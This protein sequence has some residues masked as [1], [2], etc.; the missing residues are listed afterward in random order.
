MERETTPSWKIPLEKNPFFNTSHRGISHCTFEGTTFQREASLSVFSPFNPSLTSPVTSLSM[1]IAWWRDPPSSWNIDTIA[2]LT[3][4]EVVDH[5]VI[6]IFLWKRINLDD[7]YPS[8]KLCLSTFA[9]VWSGAAFILRWSCFGVGHIEMTQIACDRLAPKNSQV[10]NF[11]F[12]L[13]T[14]GLGQ[15]CETLLRRIHK[16]DATNRSLGPGANRNISIAWGKR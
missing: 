7:D 3:F 9:H 2:S 8:L 14:F 15:L 12:V 11:S 4:Y 1:T 5:C 13:D 10:W 6:I 16:L